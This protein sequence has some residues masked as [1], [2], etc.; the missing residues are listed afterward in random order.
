MTKA[1]HHQSTLSLLSFFGDPNKYLG[2]GAT[3]HVVNDTSNLLQQMD[4]NGKNHL[5]V[6]NG[7]GLQIKGVG[8]TFLPYINGYSILLNNVLIV[9][10]ITKNMISVL[11]LTQ[12][13]FIS[14]EFLPYCCLIKSK[15]C[16]ALL[17]LEKLEGGLYKLSMPHGNQLQ[18]LRS[19]SKSFGVQL[20]LLINTLDGSTCQFH[21]KVAQFQ[22]KFQSPPLSFNNTTFDVNSC[23]S[24]VD[25]I[26][27]T[28]SS[29]FY[30]SNKDKS[31]KSSLGDCNAFLQF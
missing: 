2:S 28:L 1:I 4:Y 7:Q 29:D 27:T 11:Q 18:V 14:V 17:M 8:T 31:V 3:N 9:P 10:F 24:S 23:I 15:Q 13:N 5:L 26:S 20:S 19:H 25:N 21:T 12:D 22:V 16:R 30:A 6:G